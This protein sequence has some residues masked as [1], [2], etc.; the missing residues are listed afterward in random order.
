MLSY[1]ASTLPHGTSPEA[2]LLA[3]QCALR[4][5]NN[6]QALL[7][8]GLLKGMRLRYDQPIWEELEQANWLHLQTSDDGRTHRRPRT[9]QL[10]D[11]ATH[12]QAPSR[13]DRRQAADWA[14]RITASPKLSP[15]PPATRLT[16]LAL[17]THHSPGVAQFNT[18]SDRLYRAC[19]LE[20]DAL[21]QALDQ[22]TLAG[23]I[24]QWQFSQDREDLKWARAS[25]TP[26]ALLA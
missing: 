26:R 3:L 23:V 25:N 22:L 14:L 13:T 24:A 6:G 19:G 2:R 1:L 10:L 18:E 7:P 9:V 17:S 12:V 20:P 16:L 21:I 5:D 8:A 15:Q 4:T 11:A